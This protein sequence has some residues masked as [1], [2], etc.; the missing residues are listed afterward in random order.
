MTCHTRIYTTYS[1]PNLTKP[2]EQIANSLSIRIQPEWV[3][4]NVKFMVD[5]VE[6]PWLKP[7]N[8]FDYVHARHT[9]MAIK[10]W[11]KLMNNVYK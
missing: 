2:S 6:S 10:N 5:D 7:E 1:L 3:P 11:P 9:V 4:P 8:Y